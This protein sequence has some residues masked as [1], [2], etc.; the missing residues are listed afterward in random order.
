MAIVYDTRNGS[1]THEPLLRVRDLCVDFPLEGGEVRH[2][3]NDVSFDVP[4]GSV[5]CLVGESGSGKSV[6]AMST[7]DL[8]DEPGRIVGG[9][10]TFDGHDVLSLNHKNLER[11]RGEG[12]SMIFQEP[13]HSLNPVL[14][15][16][17]QLSETIQVHSGASRESA[18]KRS[19]QWLKRVGL[20]NPER[21][22]NMYPH[23]LSGGMAQRVMIAIALCCGPK[24]LIADEPT[25]ALDVTIQ[26]Q[27]IHL[28]LKLKEEIGLSILFI[29][30]DSGVVAE[31][32]DYV[33]VMYE[34]RVVEHGDVYGI[35]DHPQHPYTKALLETRPMIGERRHRLPTV[36]DLA[37]RFSALSGGNPL[38]VLDDAPV[39]EDGE[40]NHGRNDSRESPPVLTKPDEPLVEVKH[41]KKYFVSQ[42]G[43]FSR[44]T[45]TVRGVNDVSFEI[46]PGEAVGLVG[47]SGSGKTTL[48]QTV[49]RLQNKTGGEVRFRGRNIFD[50]DRDSLRDLRPQMQYIFQD[51]YS[52]LNPRLPIIT[53]I[54][55]PMLE[56]G[57]ADETNVRDRVAD[58]LRL[59]GMDADALDRYPHEF[60]GGQRQRIGIAR[61]MGLKPDFVVADEPVASLDVS[62]QAQ[63]I[64]LFS[65]LQER[66]GTTF[67]FI[68]HDLSVVE[69][70]CS[71]LMI[72]YLGVIVEVGSREE[73]FS[74]PIHPYTR[75]FWMRFLQRIRRGGML[76]GSR[77]PNPLRFED[78][79]RMT[80]VTGRYRSYARSMSIIGWLGAD[81]CR[82][83][84][85]VF[86]LLEWIG[87]TVSGRRRRS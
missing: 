69:H 73:I 74:N 53:A 59:C 18:W 2:A 46:F 52:S 8:V 66:R 20:P 6:T 9:T 55:E 44:T 87:F 86:P 37:P 41:L 81:A 13:M 45:H 14:R 36:R 76:C 23:E 38:A 21:V 78:R 60:S 33:V 35:F 82:I 61:A 54:G 31:V 58:V 19:M 65:D 4:H 51:P 84:H 3:V 79:M 77:I 11:L 50:L 15:V 16:G 1:D 10:I 22:M 29:T 70:L 85:C 57:L 25:T 48:G 67:M 63:I 32:A 83:V 34:G 47:E 68:S 80:F 40:W 24:L 62:V 42:E 72:M 28:L 64:N 7:I 75:S 71:R 27:I 30:H 17:K 26:A 56:H 39:P 49:L 5:T 12:I 43:F